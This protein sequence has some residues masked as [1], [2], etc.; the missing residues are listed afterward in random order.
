MI[1]PEFE[2]K[3]VMVTGAAGGIG[4]KLVQRFED[5]G[6]IV[7]GTDI[8]ASKQQHFIRGDIS[9]M[10]FQK[11]W[12]KEVLANEGRVDVLINNAGVC[13]RTALSDITE[14]EWRRVI[15][16]NLTATFFLSQICIEQMIGQKSGAIINLASLAGKVGGI[17]VGAHYSA[18]KA[19]IACLTKTLAR[20]GAGH[21]VR[22]NAVAPGVIDT[23]ITSAATP[24]QREAFKTTIPMGRIGDADEVVSPIMFLASSEASYITGATLDINGG[25][26]MD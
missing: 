25:L 23:D 19:A 11:A 24:Q 10:A 13:P 26:L 7:Y 18:S 16:I 5:C 12:L 4:S 2:D 17:A 6:A 15:D 21:G 1:Y 9:D 14:D 20:S 8:V 3:V 22:V